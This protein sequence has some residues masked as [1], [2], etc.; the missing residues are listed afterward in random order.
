MKNNIIK[1][2]IET[3]DFKMNQ[4]KANNIAE[5]VSSQEFDSIGDFLEFLCPDNPKVTVTHCFTT[6]APMISKVNLTVEAIVS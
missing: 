1:I 5:R 2:T 4:T 3:V 6:P